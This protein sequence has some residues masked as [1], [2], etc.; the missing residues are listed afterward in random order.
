[1]KKTNSFLTK[2]YDYVIIAFIY[3]LLHVFM[4]TDY[5]DDIATSQILTK[6]NFNLLQ[7][8]SDTW[9]IWSSRIFIHVAEAIF[10]YLPNYVWKTVDVIIILTAYH[11]FNKIVTIFSPNTSAKKIWPL[12]FFLSFPYSL[13]AT[14]GWITT[15][16]NYSWPFA[17]LFYGIYLFVASSRNV[18]IKWHSYILYFFALLFSCNFDTISISLFLCLLCIYVTRKTK[19][20]SFNILFL[21][22]ILASVINIAMFVLSPGNQVRLIKDAEYHNSADLLDLSFTGHLRMGI[23]STFY[24]FMSVP[25]IIL[26]TFCF[27]LIVCVFHKTSSHNLRVI[28]FIPMSLDVIWTA[29]LFFR[30]TVPNRTLTFI[31]PDSSFQ[32]SPKTEQYLAVISA[33]AIVLTIIYFLGYLTDFTDLSAFLIGNVLILGLLPEMVLGFTTTVSVSII[34]MASF[35]YFSLMF[36]AQ[37]LMNKYHILKENI[38]KHVF[39]TL[40]IIGTILNLLQMIRH[41]IVYG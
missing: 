27:L 6:Y 15:T 39:Y 2:Y 8:L 17:M 19:N 36:C 35:F 3:G 5:W 31:Y 12:L 34:R 33:L 11:Y 7:A 9:N 22:G 30:Y 20:K 4:H 18:P 29:Y 32:T 38:W 1:M 13:F 23:N 16:I 24:H 21:E 40:G 41:I 25:N 14:A 26:F 10:G 37:V 28:S